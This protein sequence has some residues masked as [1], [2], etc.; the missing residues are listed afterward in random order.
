MHPR[1]SELLGEC[2]ISSAIGRRDICDLIQLFQSWFYVRV[3]PQG[4]A[5]GRNPGLSE[6]NP[7]RIGAAVISIFS[8]LGWRDFN[9]FR[10]KG[11]RNLMELKRRLMASQ[12]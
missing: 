10:I 1:N 11:G 8:R 12:V 9:L 2:V 5:S 7:F 4:S 3:F 6:F